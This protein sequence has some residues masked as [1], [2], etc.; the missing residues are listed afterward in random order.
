MLDHDTEYLEINNLEVK[1]RLAGLLPPGMARRY[2]VLP[3]SM[4]DE[5]ITVAMADPSDTEARSA[6]LKTLGPSTYFVKADLHAIDNLLAELWPEPT[7]H[8][9]QILVWTPTNKNAGEV[10]SYAQHIAALLNSRVSQ[11][12]CQ[13]ESRDET[14]SLP[15][16]AE[17]LNS[18][19]V[20]FGIPERSTLKRLVPKLN[21]RSLLDR[22]TTSMLV[23]RNPRWPIK[24]MLLVIRNEDTDEAAIDW[25]VIMARR[26]DAAI[27]VLPILP[28][29]P[30]MYAGLNRMRYNMSTLLATDCPLGRKLR[31]IT[32]RLNEWEI[33]G[34]LRLRDETPDLQIRAELTE[35]NYVFGGLVTSLIDWA[36]QP[37]LVAKL[38]PV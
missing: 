17:R 38:Q 8:S 16:E 10:N 22:M 7:N 5:K 34:T 31:Q 35:G 1:S 15:T 11:S 12:R 26:C 4:E 30:L 18:Y 36:E 19:L 33:K 27:T 24:K 29:V 37:V 23:V 14:I 20:I 3:V 28:P 25:A 32:R 2:H 9:K 21:E 13:G 6:V